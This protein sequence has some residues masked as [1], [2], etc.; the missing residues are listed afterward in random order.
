MS[1]STEAQQFADYLEEV[2]I[3]R[4]GGPGVDLRQPATSSSRYISQPRN[5]KRCHLRRGRRQ[6]CA[7]YLGNPR[8]SGRRTCVTTLPLW[9]VSGCVRPHRP[10]G[11]RTHREGHRCQVPDRRLQTRPGAPLSSTGR[12]RAGSVRVVAR[13]GVPTRTHRQHRPFHRRLPS[14]RPSL[15]TAG[16]RKA[17]ARSCALDLPWCDLLIQN[18]TITSNAEKDKMISRETLHFFRELSAWGYRHR[19]H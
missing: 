9:R 13:P 15:A 6:R 3:R 16:R 14:G 1:I 7:W 18:G 8:V 10:E 5:Q 12:R 19:V 2:V 4:G 17:D 11:G